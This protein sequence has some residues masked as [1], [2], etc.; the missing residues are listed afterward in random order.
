MLQWNI[1]FGID[2]AN[3]LRWAPYPMRRPYANGFALPWN[4]GL[5]DISVIIYTMHLVH[6]LA[7]ESMDIYLHF[8]P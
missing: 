4:I 7:I 3:P 5:R 6:E 8:P 1:G 2:N